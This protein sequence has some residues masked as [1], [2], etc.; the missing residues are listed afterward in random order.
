[1]PD[2][3]E[4]SRLDKIAFIQ[5]GI[6]KNKK[7]ISNAIQV[8][9][10]RVANVQDGYLDLSEIKNISIDEKKLDRFLVRTGDVLLTE[11]GDF[12]KLGRGAVWKG[13]IE[14]C[15]H[16]NHV[17][18]VRP[19]KEKILP[20]FLSSLTGSSYGKKYFLS[21]SKQSTNLASINSTQLKA[22]PV[23]F[24]PLP[25]QKAIADLLSTWDEAIEKTEKLIKAK[26]KRFKWLLNE[27]IG[28][29]AVEGGVGWR[30]TFLGE[31][32]T[33]SRILDTE[34]NSRKRIS[35]RL[36]LKGVEIR[37]YRGTEVDGATKYFKRRAGQFIYGKQNVFRGSLGIV[38]KSLDGYCS[39]QDIPSFDI[40]SDVDSMWLYFYFSRQHFYKQLESITTGTGSKRLNP[41]ELYKIKISLPTIKSQKIIAAVITTAKEEI[42]LIKKMAERYRAQKRG[43]M[44]K[45]L[46]GEWRVRLERA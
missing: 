11:G 12:D 41:S 4:K 10:L 40:A 33:E 21:C 30:K 22:F 15:V 35:V 24:P 45:L 32:L 20:A 7:L 27:L 38:P 42:D 37:E 18:V 28:K 26:E 34:N 1:M 39:T 6:A 16:Q 8:P 5:T 36:H 3:W 19:N 46:T 17:F 13:E 44:Q 25:E 14:S 2:G 43:L 9:Y 29:P 23:I 31:V